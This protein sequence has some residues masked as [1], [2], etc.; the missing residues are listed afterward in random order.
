MSACIKKILTIAGS[1][2]IGGAG[3][4]ADIRIA[5]LLGCAC[6]TAITSVT[7]QN[8]NGVYDIHHV[9]SNVIRH[10]IG[11]VLKS[12][13]NAIKIGMLGTKDVVNT[14]YSVL[15]DAKIPIILDP[16]FVATSG[17]LLTDHNGF[18]ALKRLFTLSYLITPNIKEA[19]F[20]CDTKI[21]NKND[22]IR[23]GSKMLKLG[24]ENILIKGGHLDNAQIVDVLITKDE[25]IFEFLH[26][27]V[28]VKTTHGTGCR[29]SSAIACNIAKGLTLKNAVKESI[30]C[31]LAEIELMD[32]FHQ[33]V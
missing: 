19:E 31:T 25:K 17:A 22:M 21:K 10:Q 26:K 23:A 9:P 29:L 5:T 30:N 12:G 14:V 3:I 18:E 32:L 13:V 28:Q 8:I 15:L 11:I 6:A 20:I 4:Q 33:N 16:V 27:R 24:T 1:D 2:S 7:V